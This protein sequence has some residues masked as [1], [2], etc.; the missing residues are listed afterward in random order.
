LNKHIKPDKAH[1][2][3][4][5]SHSNTC[6]GSFPKIRG[7]LKRV[8]HAERLRSLSSALAGIWLTIS[9]AALWN[10][11][12]IFSSIERDELLFAVREPSGGSHQICTRSARIL[13]RCNCLLGMESCCC[14]ACKLLDGRGASATHQ[15]GSEPDSAF[16]KTSHVSSVSAVRT[17]IILNR[18]RPC[19]IN[20]HYRS[21]SHIL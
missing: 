19:G 16:D 9:F 11:V 15:N 1:L 18:T 12:K 20:H 17:R 10:L 2:V 4:L 7:D 6:G 21:Y 14:D 13:G 5:G 8:G 3:E